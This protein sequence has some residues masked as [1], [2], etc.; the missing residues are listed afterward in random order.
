MGEAPIHLG[1]LK[2][3][4]RGL[5]LWIGLSAFAQLHAGA[6]ELGAGAP[7]GRLPRDELG[8]GG[9]RLRSR[10]EAA[11]Q[12]IPRAEG[13]RFGVGE[14]GARLLHLRLR[15]GERGRRS[16]HG[17][18]RLRERDV[19]LTNR[20]VEGFT[21]KSEERRSGGD[22]LI[23]L[24]EDLDDLPRDSRRDLRGEGRD[25]SSLARRR[26]KIAGRMPS[27]IG[28]QGQQRQSANLASGI[29]LFPIGGFVGLGR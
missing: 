27:Q 28:Q 5:D 1:L 21:I 2:L 9:L 18:R 4:L 29:P 8:F 6:V 15:S 3:D 17:P 14:R 7:Q 19:G 26:I 12:K 10:R 23:V 25:R 22:A 11:L 24:N 13:A 16:A 20:E